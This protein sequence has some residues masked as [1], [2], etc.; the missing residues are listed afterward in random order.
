MLATRRQTAKPMKE[1]ATAA[2]LAILNRMS[3][4]KKRYILSADGKAI[5]KLLKTPTQTYRSCNPDALA[6]ALSKIS[7]AQLI[8]TAKEL[9]KLKISSNK[10]PIVTGWE[11]FHGCL[12]KHLKSALVVTNTRLKIVEYPD[13]SKQEREAAQTDAETAQRVRTLL[14]AQEQLRA[15]HSSASVKYKSMVRAREERGRML[16]MHMPPPSADG[17]TRTS[18][19]G[20]QRVAGQR[21]KELAPARVELRRST[22]RRPK[23]STKIPLVSKTEWFFAN[24]LSRAGMDVASIGNGEIDASV[25]K[26]LVTQGVVDAIKQAYATHLSS[27]ERLERRPTHRLVVI[28]PR[29][30]RRLAMKAKPES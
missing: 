18:P 25:A 26:S 9:K 17:G 30:T 16:E 23:Q 28:K 22:P 14:E 1:R 8:S 12:L 10:P 29:P 19:A 5:V 3:D 13:A 6:K 11:A 20:G 4:A 24:V 21:Q 7:T 27:E 15:H 2:R